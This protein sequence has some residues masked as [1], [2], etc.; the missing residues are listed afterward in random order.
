MRESQCKKP[1]SL[2]H[3]VRRISHAFE[4][5]IITVFDPMVWKTSDAPLQNKVLYETCVVRG[6]NWRE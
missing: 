4:T 5:A 6:D 3:S 1:L 2:K